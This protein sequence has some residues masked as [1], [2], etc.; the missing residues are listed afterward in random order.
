MLFAQNKILSSED[1]RLDSLHICG[2]DQ[3]YTIDIFGIP[4]KVQ[5]GG[6]DLITLGDG[7]ND[8]NLSTTVFYY[9]S[10]KMFFYTYEIY[11][12]VYQIY[13]QNSQSEVHLGNGLDFNV[14]DS[15]SVV[16]DKLKDYM[17][18]KD[19]K[20]INK[21]NYTLSFKAEPTTKECQMTGFIR[22]SVNTSGVVTEISIGML[23]N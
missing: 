19:T 22:F 6:R 2:A 14:G 23:K 3:R 10:F 21:G 13:V 16:I 17:T 8:T 7:I 20:K 9:P 12:W 15:V 18:P 4:E 5:Y 11:Q 1:L